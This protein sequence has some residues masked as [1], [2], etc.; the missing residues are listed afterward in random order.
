[1][2]GRQKEEQELFSLV[3]MLTAVAIGNI[4]AARTATGAIF[5]WTRFI[6]GERT[7]LMVLA[8]EKLDCLLCLG[9]A[10]HGNE[11]KPTGFTREFILDECSFPHL[12]GLR[13]KVLQ[14]DF[15]GVE[16]KIPDVEFTGHDSVFPKT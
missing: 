4:F 2:M 8:V 14:F 9:I 1:M 11:G 10:G 16:G 13:E 6:H 5:T 15:S 7:S 12:A 3:A